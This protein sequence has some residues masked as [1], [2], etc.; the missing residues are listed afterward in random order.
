MEATD[1]NTLLVVSESKRQPELLKHEFEL[2]YLDYSFSDKPSRNGLSAWHDDGCIQVNAE[3][4]H[5]N[6]VYRQ[7]ALNRLFAQEILNLKPSRVLII[8]LNG[9]SIDLLRVATL[10]G[11]YADVLIDNAAQQSLPQAESQW[12]KACLNSAAKI[13]IEDV[14]MADSWLT[15]IE[16]DVLPWG[17]QWGQEISAGDKAFSFDYGIY[18]FCLRDHPLLMSMQQADVRHFENCKQVLD[19]GCGAGLF[20][21]LLE[22]QDIS[23][24]GVERDPTVAEYGSATGLNIVC[25]D[26]LKY[27]ENNEREVDGIYCSHFVEHLPIELVETLIEHIAKR[28]PSDGVAV[29]TFPD[30]ESIRS[31]LLGFWRDPEHVRFYHPELITTIASVHGLA[32]EWS[33]YDDQPHHVYP[34]A[35]VPEE[36]HLHPL[37]ATKATVKSWWQRILS[38]L[39]IA[40]TGQIEQLG[41][42][43][44]TVHKQ[45]QTIAQLKDRTEKLWQ[46]NQT[47]AWN[48]NVTLRFRKR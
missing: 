24:H 6:G 40:S 4:Q 21:Q 38:R 9:S 1:N 44:A 36:I 20:L 37:D 28:L 7:Q 12:L 3:C 16:S 13:Y 26:A 5:F 11:V 30:P 29:L 33:S 8:G 31:Q 2:H 23:A 41:D 10:M 14:E 45:Q 43:K 27:L 15:Y 46:V 22:E 18:E 42:L 32:C 35:E 25:E 17:E 39:G 47:W 19:L 48:D 34:F